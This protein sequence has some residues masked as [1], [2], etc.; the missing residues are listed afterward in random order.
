MI[1]EGRCDSTRAKSTSFPSTTLG[2]TSS[3]GTGE[4][5]VW[6][7]YCDSRLAWGPTGGDLD[8]GLGLATVENRWNVCSD[9]LARFLIPAPIMITSL[10]AHLPN[11][12]AVTLVLIDVPSISSTSQN[13]LSA[14]YPATSVPIPSKR[15]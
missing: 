10:P 7:A 15:S 8:P 11:S 9:T 14:R 13:T 6:G 5:E 4:M 2:K 1:G 3:K 12:P